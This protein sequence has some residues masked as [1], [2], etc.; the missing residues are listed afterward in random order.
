MLKV[1]AKTQLLEWLK[2]GIQHKVITEKKAKDLYEE[3]FAPM[4]ELDFL[5]MLHEA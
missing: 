5:K 3:K 2:M 4:K 1:K